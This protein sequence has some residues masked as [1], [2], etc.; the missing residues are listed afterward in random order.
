VVTITKQKT[1]QGRFWG[2]LQ[3]PECCKIPSVQRNKSKLYLQ[4]LL[5]LRSCLTEPAFR[6]L[7]AMHPDFDPLLLD[8]VGCGSTLGNLLR[9]CAGIDKDFRFDIDRVRDTIFFIRKESSP[10]ALIHN[11][12]GYGHSFP[13]AHTIWEPDVKGSASH[14]R[15][16][17]YDFGGLKFLVRS[18]NDGYLKQTVDRDTQRNDAKTANTSK[19]L[20]ESV[21]NL[22]KTQE[23]IEASTLLEALGGLHLLSGH[24]TSREEA[25]GF[26]KR[27][28]S[29]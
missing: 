28:S 13:E 17:Q 5:T 24:S 26:H 25:G 29:T 22:V 1:A 19:D 14:Q 6:A 15:I 21:E 9:F 12:R 11:I 2:V 18:E 8:V 16:I 20:P 4:A 23:K 27:P 10:T 7:L 3:R